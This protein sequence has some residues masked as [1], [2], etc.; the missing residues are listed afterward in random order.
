MNKNDEAIKLQ[1]T[2]KDKNGSKSLE[3]SQISL[4]TTNQWLFK[5]VG[6][7]RLLTVRTELTVLGSTEWQTQKKT[8]NKK[9]PLY[10]P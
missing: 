4:K 10:H 5:T 3:N 6:R 1:L 7:L 8:K 2:T 9:A